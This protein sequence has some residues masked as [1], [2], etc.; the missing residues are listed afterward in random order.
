MRLRIPL[1]K[2]VLPLPVI[3]L[4]FAAAPAEQYISQTY[5]DTSIQRAY[6]NLNAATDV[7]GMGMKLEDAIAS[8]KQIA[9]RLK[10]IA[11]GNPNEKYILWKVN[12][13]EG[14]IYLEESGLLLEKNQKRQKQ[15]NDLVGT[16][17]AE[18][19]KP[20]PD[21]LILS[22]LYNQALSI[23]RAKSYE[24]GTSLENRKNNILREAEASFNKA[25]SSGDFDVAWQELVY[26][27][28]NKDYLGI[29]ITQYSQIAAKIQSKITL[30]N[31]REFIVRNEDIT[32]LLIAN[33]CFFEARSALDV[34]D[35]RLESIKNMARKVEWD[36]FYFRNKRL[37]DA[38]VRKEDSLVRVNI[39]MINDQGVIAASDFLEK[40]LKK[41]G[42]SPE[43]TSKVE[44]AILE[45]AMAG[46]KTQDTAV[47]KELASA[48]TTAAADSSS[49]MSDLMSAAKKKAQAKA[50]SEKAAQ[51]SS[52]RLTSTEELRLANMRVAQENQ[53]RR[54]EE[55]MKENKIKANQ[56]IINIY[57]WLERKE[58]Q[59]AYD[60]YLDRQSFLARYV[61][62]PSFVALDSTVNT[63][64]AK[65][66]KK[67][68]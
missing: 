2:A 21:F 68:K 9:S 47:G 32:E 35:D 65:M 25:L 1:F 12:E 8:A 17:N 44:F 15:V 11:K 36:K 67:K 10:N 55:M 54:S 46:R 66:K 5:I 43:K 28:N 61:A 57:V 63:E 39:F 20:R 48:S 6:Y 59:K 18:L 50:D 26:L 4:F 30:D 53:Q 34:L 29:S 7:S 37:R 56:I 40:R 41:Y 3:L 24:F 38:M 22:Q 23:D 49:M 58:V 42:V 27:K 52:A 16:F 13:L 62:T 60:E 19:A 31:E 14:Q 64:Y 45:K 51:A 33:H